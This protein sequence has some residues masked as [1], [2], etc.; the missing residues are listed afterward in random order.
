LR[1]Q[2]KA[3]QNR[4]SVIA[5]T[6]QRRSMYIIQGT[7]RTEWQHSTSPVKEVRYSITLRTLRAPV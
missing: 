7:A 4:K 3:K 6:A 5:F 2:E 1:L